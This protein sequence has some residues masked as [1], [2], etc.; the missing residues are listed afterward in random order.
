MPIKENMFVICEKYTGILM[1]NLI[2]WNVFKVGSFL[3][4]NTI[5]LFFMYFYL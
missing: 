4:E 5:G 2:L 3:K 1:K